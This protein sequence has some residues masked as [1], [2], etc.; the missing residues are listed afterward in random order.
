MGTKATKLCVLLL[1]IFFFTT[2]CGLAQ[3]PPATKALLEYDARLPLNTT[4]KMLEQRAHVE[5]LDLQYDSPKG[6]RV[7]AFVVQ[8]RRAG[9]FAGIV[10]GHWGLGERTEFLPDAIRLAEAGAICVLIDYP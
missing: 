9:K 10:F 1:A 3:V 6:G 8:P 2:V 5:I 7:S 4:E